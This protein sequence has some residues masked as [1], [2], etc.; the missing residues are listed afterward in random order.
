MPTYN[1]S[2]IEPLE[3]WGANVWS[4]AYGWG[5]S[6]FVVSSQVYALTVALEVTESITLLADKVTN[7]QWSTEVLETVT[8]A[9]TI[10]TISFMN[11]PVNESVTP[12]DTITNAIPWAAINTSSTP[13][14]TQITAP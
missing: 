3:G 1:E 12:V 14:W 8:A 6:V 4:G 5:D 7:G 9:E 11:Q 2:I 13:N 10:T